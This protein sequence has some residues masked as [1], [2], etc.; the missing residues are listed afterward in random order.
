[1]MPLLFLRHQTHLARL[2]ICFRMDNVVAVHC[3]RRTGSSSSLPLLQTTELLFT[4]AASCH[5]TLSVVH[6]PGRDNVWPDELSRTESWSVEW[7]LHPEA[8]QGLVEL[9]GRP[10]VNLLAAT[11]N[12]LLPLYLT[13]TV[14]TEAGGPGTFMTMWD[15]WSYIYL[16]PTPAAAV[17][18]AVCGRL[19]DFR[20]RVL[21]V[22]SLWKVQPWCQQLFRW[23][24]HPLPL[25]SHS[26]T[27]RGFLQSG[28]SSDFHAWCFSRNV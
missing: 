19:Q 20:G 11:D 8:F 21:L 15:T 26:I 12:H 25:S 1:M 9:F 3:V 6:L 24:P 28:M 4:L 22:A 10:E 5:L 2:H 7:A 27:G 16:F 18:M 13:R 14:T 23:C 17:M